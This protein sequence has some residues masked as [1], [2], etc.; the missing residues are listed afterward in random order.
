MIIRNLLVKDS[1]RRLAISDILQDSY[2]LSFMQNFIDTNGQSL[3]R[4][5][6]LNVRKTARGIPEQESR[7]SPIKESSLI[8]ETPKEKMARKKREVAEKEAERLKNAA[9]EAYVHNQV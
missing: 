9:K 5:R 2:S 1:N 7:Q 8:Y 6:S 3:T 4:I